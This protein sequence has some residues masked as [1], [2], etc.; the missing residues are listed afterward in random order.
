MSKKL[1]IVESPTKVK[2]IG[3]LLGK[4]YTVL[5]SFGHVRDLPSKDGSVD[6]DNDF[7][8]AYQIID[9][10]AKH[11]D[12]IAKAA[13]DCDE[14]LLATDL[15]R[16]GEAISWH[17]AE[18]LRGK[19]LLK[20]KIIRRVTF[21]EITPRAIK[22][23][24]AKPR[25]LAMNLVNA[26]QA[27]RALDYLVGFNLSPL[28]WRKVQPGLS[29]GRVQSPA[30]RMIVEREEE[31]ERFIARE[32]WTIDAGLN[33]HGA[34]FKAKLTHYQGEKLDQFE[35]NNA[36]I[37]G[38]V[39]SE[40]LG[41]AM[42]QGTGPLGA[43][44]VTDIQR[45]DRLRRPSAPFTTS[46]MQQEASRKLGF[47]AQRTMRVAQSL[48]EGAQTGEGQVGLITYMRTD[49][50]S[51][52][53]D[54][55]V[56][57]RQLIS[58]QFGP[59]LLPPA[60]VEYK[61]K[62]KN[63]QE[64]HEAIRPSLAFRTPASLR[65]YLNADEYALYELIWK[66]TVACQMKP[67]T[68]NTVSVDF[69]CGRGN[70]FRASGS[71][72]VEP[73]FLLVYEEGRDAKSEDDD[74][75]SLLPVFTLGDK[76][77][78]ETLVADQHF[79]EPPPRFNEA[80]LVKAMEEI[81][82]GRPSTY[83]TIIQVLLAREY[84]TLDS[85]RFYPT[86]IGRVVSNFLSGHFTQYVDYDF[87]AKLEDELDAVARGE[88]DYVPVL[89]RFWEPFKKL[90][91]E[92]SESVTRAEVSNARVIGVHPESGKEMSVRL[93]R[94]GPFAQIGTKD[95]EDKPK[96]ASLRPGQRM[97]SITFDEALK[98]FDLP[99]KLGLDHQNREITIAI[100]RFGPF[101]KVGTMFVSLPKEDDP[102]EVTLERAIEIIKAK[103]QMLAERVIKTFNDG[104]I[105]VLK[106]KYGPYITDGEKNGK[107]AKDVD[108]NEL[109]LEDCIASLAAAPKG[110][111]K[112]KS[113]SAKGATERA[114]REVARQRGKTAA[115]PKKA[116]AKKAADS[117]TAKARV[118]S[119]TAKLLSNDEISAIESKKAPA[120]KAPAKKAAAKKAAAKKSA[121]KKSAAKKAGAKKAAAKKSVSAGAKAAVAA[122]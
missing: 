90:V 45:K 50:V 36:D 98:L 1:L 7:Q 31:I 120:K 101:A 78:L 109:T 86:D 121:A 67:A 30:L 99:R 60:A 13:R 119:E 118:K 97:D 22:E 65:Q 89:R 38:R 64:A 107:I 92:K 27:R 6:V 14:I 29:A 5:A 66:R 18:I 95:D 115:A 73:G 68:L 46:T 9:R 25:E 17:I 62:S 54:A 39:R 63:A 113:A 23:A 58:Q 61:N 34:A 111:P 69:E 16:E 84:V 88:Q 48:Y 4:D 83:A 70:I 47:G 28:L 72:I 110:K 59:N 71:T 49:S 26:Q 74:N 106:G 33:Q 41:F 103:E 77:P 2:T 85:K 100:G 24:L 117:K 51:I 82:I 80:T 11:V 96:F 42:R 93:G 76:V 21:S 55:L 87:T 102:Y 3:K 15:D 91:D 79:T 116:A 122:S 108:P 104:A 40:L 114:K 8:M 52:S 75:S 35:L 105:Q 81:G 19:K 43:L 12:Q 32:Y 94:F 37:S 112:S 10:N 20:D 56:E 53:Q 57:L 44:K